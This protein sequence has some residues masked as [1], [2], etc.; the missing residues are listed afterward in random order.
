M[1]WEVDLV[2][3]EK[4]RNWTDLDL[5]AV[6]EDTV[7]TREQGNRLFKQGKFKFAKDKYERVSGRHRKAKIEIAHGLLVRLSSTEAR[8]F[9]L[10]Q[11]P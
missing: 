5:D 2:S 8:S 9:V 11:N 6:L 1:V 3:F 7:K 4:V 10:F